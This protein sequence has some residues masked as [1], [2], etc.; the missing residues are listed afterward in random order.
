MRNGVKDLT[1]G[2]STRSIP[3]TFPA[4]SDVQKTMACQ[5]LGSTPI[6]MML[7][8]SEDEWTSLRGPCHLRWPTT[9]S[10]VSEHT[11][12]DSHT[13]TASDSTQSNRAA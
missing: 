11:S 1:F 8:M 5:S 6:M 13:K 10:N 2:L 9:P 7:D 3:M 4:D 12:L